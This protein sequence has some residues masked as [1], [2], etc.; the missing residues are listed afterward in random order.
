M[1]LPE[2]CS[3]WAAADTKASKL[4]SVSLYPV[5]CEFAMFPEMFCSA[6][7][8]ACKPPTAVVRAS[9]IP[10]TWSP[11]AFPAAAGMTCPGP[12]QWVDHR[13]PRANENNQSDQM[14]GNP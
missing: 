1:T 14:L 4:V 5:V 9:K 10:M 11:P 3:P 12:H 13:N 6:N 2:V 7:D 8:C